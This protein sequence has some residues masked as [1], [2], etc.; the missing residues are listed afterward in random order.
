M[1]RAPDMTKTTP[2]RRQCHLRTHHDAL[3]Q[4]SKRQE[5]FTLT[6]YPV[7]LPHDAKS[8]TELGSMGPAQRIVRIRV[9]APASHQSP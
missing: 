2:I 6:K 4:I 8:R 5:L 1:T 3:I 7:S 9:K